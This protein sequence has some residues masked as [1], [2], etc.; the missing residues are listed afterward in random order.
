MSTVDVAAL[1]EAAEAEGSRGW[2]K[3]DF[4][5]GAD[6]AYRPLWGVSNEAYFNPPADEDEPWL[7]VEVHT[8][9]EATATYIAAANPTTILA[10]LDRL[11]A[12]EG[13]V[14]RC[15]ALADEW[16][17]ADDMTQWG[18]HSGNRHGRA[19]RAALDGAQ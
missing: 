4:N 17:A 19:I 16:I 18:D 8:G 5:E 12:A 14:E 3:V 9:T 6:P 1:Q 2:Y 13:A 15:R 11:E 10:L 7:A